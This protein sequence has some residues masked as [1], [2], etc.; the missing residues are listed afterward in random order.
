V[1]L[2]FMDFFSLVGLFVISNDD[3]KVSL[4]TESISIWFGKLS[5]N[6]RRYEIWELKVKRRKLFTNQLSNAPYIFCQLWKIKS[7]PRGNIILNFN[8]ILFL[9]KFHEIWRIVCWWF[10]PLWSWRHYFVI[11]PV[12]RLIN[13]FR[14]LIVRWW[15]LL[16][17]H[18]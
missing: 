18:L 4:H 12:N 3:R 7:V 1:V 14:V 16:S 8:Y 13:G 2:T 5:K 17:V 15:S 6:N 9:I 10:F 11:T